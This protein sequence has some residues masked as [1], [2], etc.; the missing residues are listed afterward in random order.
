MKAERN[1]DA[2]A[3]KLLHKDAAAPPDAVWARI[4]AQLPA[5]GTRFIPFF[6]IKYAWL[7]V[8][9]AVFTFAGWWFFESQT[10]PFR[11]EKMHSERIHQAAPSNNSEIENSETAYTGSEK[12][13]AT[14]EANPA[15]DIHAS[16]AENAQISNFPSGKL[17]NMRAQLSHPKSISNIANLD[18]LSIT[19]ISDIY[20][21]NQDYFAKAYST[22]EHRNIISDMAPR[23]YSSLSE[24]AGLSFTPL[25][26][27]QPAQHLSTPELWSRTED[28]DF[29]PQPL[30]G[31]SIGV[32]ADLRSTSLN[33]SSAREGSSQLVDSLNSAEMASANFGGAISIGYHLKPKWRI[34]SGLAFAKWCRTTKYPILFSVSDAYE[35]TLA[36]ADQTIPLEQNIIS[37]TGFQTV[38]V[39]APSQT[40]INTQQ[41]IPPDTSLA[42]QLE[43]EECYSL[44]QIPLLI[45]Y[46]H[47][48]GRFNFLPGAGVAYE[49]VLKRSTNVIGSASQELDG[50]V[51][52]QEASQKNFLSFIATLHVEYQLT[53]HLSFRTGAN[54]KAWL[55][56][57][58]QSDLIQTYPRVVSVD[59]GIIYT[60][61]RKYL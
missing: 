19:K 36:T 11:H 54:Y 33:I 48:A 21:N 60:F 25:K 44:L 5:A 1:M 39:N 56:P 24:S 7:G 61:Q 41:I 51:M 53:E 14:K 45:E 47:S 3:R 59:A 37:A 31:W 20:T 17:V 32:F 42:K 58:Y 10:L 2:Q 18:T 12:Y 38:N 49:Y 35:G 27:M 22:T 15:K 26:S 8:A 50:T 9:L 23:D 43:I 16:L 4:E 52:H 55:T 13:A 34:S 28:V 29:G 30:R 40:L 6:L 57:V 46:H